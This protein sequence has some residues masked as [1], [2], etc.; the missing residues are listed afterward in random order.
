MTTF[1]VVNVDTVE[2]FRLFEISGP[3]GHCDR[4]LIKISSRYT[5][6]SMQEV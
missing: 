2:D 6:S 5:L 1:L 3:G 4:L